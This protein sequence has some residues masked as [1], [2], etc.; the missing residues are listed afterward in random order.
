MYRQIRGLKQ[1]PSES[2]ETPHIVQ[3]RSLVG[4]FQK[5]LHF[6][7]EWLPGKVFASLSLRCHRLRSSGTFAT[8]AHPGG[9]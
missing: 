7:V 3:Q 2:L 9:I 4:I 1:R 6:I 8:R 5:F